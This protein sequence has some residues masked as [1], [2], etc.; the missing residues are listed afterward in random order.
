MTSTDHAKWQDTFDGGLALTA[1]YMSFLVEPRRGAWYLSCTDSR[2]N[3]WFLSKDDAMTYAEC[4][5]GIDRI[6]DGKIPMPLRMEQIAFIL[7][8]GMTDR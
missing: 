5:G 1:N 7:D 2:L 4:L 6:K 3:G 8:N